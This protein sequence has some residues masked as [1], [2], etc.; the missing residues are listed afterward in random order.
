MR[1]CDGCSRR[2]LLTLRNC[3]TVAYRSPSASH[4][5][6]GPL[7]CRRP[8][9][10]PL[11]PPR[12]LPS[13]TSSPRLRS[14]FVHGTADPQQADP[15]MQIHDD[16]FMLV[17]RV[18][19]TTWIGCSRTR[20]VGA[21]SVLNT[22]MSVAVRELQCSSCAVNKPLGLRVMWLWC[23]LWLGFIGFVMVM[24]RVRMLGWGSGY[25]VRI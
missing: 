13:R 4:S 16:A 17:T 23:G 18:I 9:I 3:S 1:R 11:P 12:I 19:V 10:R 7:I 15:C 22:R 24:I 14:R 8:D 20:T 6:L 2:R 25:W 21:Q 5:L